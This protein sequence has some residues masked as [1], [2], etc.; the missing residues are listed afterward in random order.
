[1]SEDCNVCEIPELELGT[2]IR[3]RTKFE[4]EDGNEVTLFNLPKWKIFFDPSGL[5][6]TFVASG[7]T[8]AVG[9][10]T[11]WFDTLWQSS[12][13]IGQ[14]RLEVSGQISSSGHMAIDRKYFVL[15]QVVC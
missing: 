4:D 12:G 10:H 5:G 14:H 11:S 15:K 7:D 13:D 2:F 8:V 6:G 3:A 9:G 1:M